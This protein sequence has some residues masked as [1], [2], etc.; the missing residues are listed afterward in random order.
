MKSSI[1]DSN[2]VSDVGDDPS[3]GMVL[4]FSTVNSESNK[5]SNHVGIT[6]AYL[7]AT[8]D[9]TFED[10]DSTF[11]NAYAWSGGFAYIVQTTVSLTNTVIEN[12]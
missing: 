1:I 7:M 12:I 9:S 5:F 10:N 3:S 6:G 8:S 2:A 4:I 11:R